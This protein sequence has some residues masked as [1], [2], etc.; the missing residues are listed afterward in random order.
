MARSISIWD[1]MA[2]VD[3]GIEREN[4]L[5]QKMSDKYNMQHSARLMKA[6]RMQAMAKRRK[7]QE[8]AGSMP[9]MDGQM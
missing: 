9:P 3:A 5:S 4:A 1:K 7:M 2:G 8:T 6:K